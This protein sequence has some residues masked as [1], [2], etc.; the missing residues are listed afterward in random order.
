LP[1]PSIVTG[2]FGALL[3]GLIPPML[4]AGM[5]LG[6]SFFGSPLCASTTPAIE[7][8]HTHAIANKSVL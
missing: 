4:M 3:A 5:D 8:V 7:S 6:A 1:S 2:D